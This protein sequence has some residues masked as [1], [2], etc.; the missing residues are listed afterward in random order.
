MRNAKSWRLCSRQWRSKNEEMGGQFLA[1]NMKKEGVVQTDSGLQ[2]EI[3]EAGTGEQ[4]AETDTVVVHYRGTLVD[5]TEFDSS[6]KRNT[7]ATFPVNGVIKGW[8]EGLQL[9][10]EGAKWKFYVPSELAYG[11]QGAGGVIGPNAILVFEVELKEI[12]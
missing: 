4:P 9:M 2:Y 5:G 11:Q 12:K 10:R 7:P 6:Y 3:I 8:Q 1:E